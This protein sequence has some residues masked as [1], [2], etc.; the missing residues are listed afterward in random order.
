MGNS[1]Y[2]VRSYVA[3]VLGATRALLAA[4]NAELEGEGVQGDAAARWALESASRT[5]T[6][7]AA[8]LA[9]HLARLGGRP[10]D[11]AVRLKPLAAS[12]SAKAL[13]D[14]YAAIGLNRAGSMMLE[15][16][17]R[18]LGFSATAALASR[19]RD[20]LDRVLDRLGEVQGLKIAS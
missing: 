17:A 19:H 11:A 2:S 8:E 5:L 1:I 9:E 15:T 12:S 10:E 3:E 18:T 7:H 14:V 16:T 20:E 6:M 13:R 4:L